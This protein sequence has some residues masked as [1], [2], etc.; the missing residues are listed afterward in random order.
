MRN[1]L[2]TYQRIDFDSNA[3][4]DRQ[5]GELNF[6]GEVESG[7]T[8]SCSCQGQLAGRRLVWLGRRQRIAAQ[9]IHD[10]CRLYIRA[11]THHNH[12]RKRRIWIIRA[13]QSD[14]CEVGENKDFFFECSSN[15]PQRQ[16]LECFL[17]QIARSDLLLTL[18][19]VAIEMNSDVGY[20]HGAG[21]VAGHRRRGPTDVAQDRQ[22]TDL[23]A[24]AGY[25][26][27]IQQQVALGQ[28]LKWNQSMLYMVA[29][30]SVF[31]SIKFFWQ[32][33]FS[34]YFTVKWY[35][36]IS[37]PFQLEGKKDYQHFVGRKRFEQRDIFAVSSIFTLGKLTNYF[38]QYCII[39]EV[40]RIPKLDIL[41]HL[42]NYLLLQ[43]ISLPGI[44]D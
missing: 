23:L 34:E 32:V 17:S 25:A 15:N 2:S 5:L 7:M 12:K 36:L 1:E 11:A 28:E 20:G 42:D 6:L 27:A 19:E 33:L 16:T 44:D 22:T 30:R 13:N 24:Q 3:E 21:Q 29:K 14:K 39:F 40:G 18:A 43:L 41:S 9:Q 8:A 26:H 35:S 38:Y 37:Y 10:A 4:I 31:S